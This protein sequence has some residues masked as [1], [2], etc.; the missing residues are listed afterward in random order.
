MLLFL[1]AENMPL[2]LARRY[3]G[4]AAERNL[5]QIFPPVVSWAIRPTVMARVGIA[6]RHL[7][8]NPLLLLFYTETTVMYSIFGLALFLGL[9][10]LVICLLQK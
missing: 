4:P 3:T 10:L 5:H 2:L 1:P 6:A 7:Q 9:V 8:I